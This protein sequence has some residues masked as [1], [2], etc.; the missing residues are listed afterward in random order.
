MTDNQEALT[1]VT[2]DLKKEYREDFAQLL[3]KNKEL[4]AQ[5]LQLQ[6]AYEVLKQKYLQERKKLQKLQAAYRD[7]QHVKQAKA[8]IIVAKNRFNETLSRFY[9]EIQQLKETSPLY[10]LLAAKELELDRIKKALNVVSQSHDDRKAIESLVECHLYERDQLKTMIEKAESRLHTQLNQIRD[11][12]F[13]SLQFSDPSN[14]QKI[15]ENAIKV[16]ED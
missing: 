5:M 7:N 12:N 3:E 6:N 4:V 1:Q 8:E 9:R 16:S 11:A 13:L 15:F 14:C 10:D 2:E